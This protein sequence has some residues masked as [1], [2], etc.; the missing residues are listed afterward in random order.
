M[1]ICVVVSAQW[2]ILNFE[3]HCCT[4]ERYFTNMLISESVAPSTN[5]A[6]PLVGKQSTTAEWCYSGVWHIGVGD[7]LAKNYRKPINRYFRNYLNKIIDIENDGRFIEKLLIS[8]KMIFLTWWNGQ[9]FLPRY[10]CCRWFLYMWTISV[11][12]FS[13]VFHISIIGIKGFFSTQPLPLNGFTTDHWQH[14]CGIVR[15]QLC[16]AMFGMV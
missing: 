1:D 13:M 2:K 3:S 7:I 14:V 8:K 4:I 6:T 16:A 9:W 11:N 15:S 12:G 10:H 5:K